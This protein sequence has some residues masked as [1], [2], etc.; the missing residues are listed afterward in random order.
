MSIYQPRQYASHSPF[1]RYSFLLHHYCFLLLILV[2]IAITTCCL[3]HQ[4]PVLPA[5]LIICIRLVPVLVPLQRAL[6]IS[7]TA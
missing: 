5:T 2:H 6:P 7:M 1:R 3:I 4:I